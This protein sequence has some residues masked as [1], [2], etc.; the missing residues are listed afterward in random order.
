VSKRGWIIFVVIVVVFLGGLI[1]LSN[2]SKVNVASINPNVLQ[3]ANAQNG[4]IAEHVY[5]KADS[6][7]VLVEYGDFQCPYCGNEHPIIKQVTSQYQGQIAF[8]FRNFPL[9]SLHP[10]A[11][12]AAGAVEAA[13][14]QNRYWDMHNLIFE[15]QSTWENLT[16]T[17][18]TNQFIAYAKQLGLDTTKFTTDMASTSVSK[19]ISVDQAIGQKLGIDSTPSFYLDGKVVDQTVWSDATKLSAALNTELKKYG[20]A[21]P[22]TS[23]SN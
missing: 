10:N 12:A 4:N 21:E 15:T 11:L 18:R 13:G 14:L 8:V 2:S 16:G 19:K 22:T 9:T 17:D 23:T 5:G 7:V 3:K 20:I 6:K 1:V